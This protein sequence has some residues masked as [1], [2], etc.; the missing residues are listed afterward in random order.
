MS[1]ATIKV[2][3]ITIL[4]ILVIS[5]LTY[6]IDINI[7]SPVSLGDSGQSNVIRAMNVSTSSTVTT[8][9]SQILA[10]STSRVYA[11]IVNDGANPVYISLAGSPA[12]AGSG[13]R[14]NA[15]GGSYE[16]NFSNLV[17]SGI[18]AISTG[19]SSN[20]TVTASQ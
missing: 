7:S 17:I 20:V 2:V 11:A 4:T 16:I 8:S 3:A 15:L 13:I 6:V 14:L 18:T 12:I 9:S 19:G 1:K 5:T 10:T